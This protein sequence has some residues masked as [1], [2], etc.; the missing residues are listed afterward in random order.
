MKRSR[1]EDTL[2]KDIPKDVLENVI[3]MPILLRKVK[4]MERAM[5]GDSFKFDECNHKGCGRMK[6]RSP[7]N[8]EEFIDNIVEQLSYNDHRKGYHCPSRS[9]QKWFCKDHMPDT[10]YCPTCEA[11]RI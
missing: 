3:L 6:C 2:G 8:G 5:N 1:E 11:E 4:L 10:R 7:K 9:C